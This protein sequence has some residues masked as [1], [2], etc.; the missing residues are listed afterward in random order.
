MQEETLRVTDETGTL[1]FSTGGKWLHPLFALEDY[2]AGHPAAVE[3]LRLEDKIVGLGA[4]V[5]I[6]RMGFVRCHARLLSGRAVPLLE[7]HGVSFTWDE[8][9]DQI[10]CMTET[11]LSADAPLEDSYAEL[12]RRAGRKPPV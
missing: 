9:V 3:T 12:S 8:K 6:V 4:A 2:L 5:L 7:K 11:V 1:Y 10:Q